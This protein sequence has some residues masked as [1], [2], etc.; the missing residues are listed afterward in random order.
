LALRDC[1]RL[2]VPAFRASERCDWQ[3]SILGRLEARPETRLRFPRRPVLSLQSSVGIIRHPAGLHLRVT[4]NALDRLTHAHLSVSNRC[5]GSVQRRQKCYAVLIGNSWKRS[6]KGAGVNECKKPDFNSRLPYSPSS[7][8]SQEG[9]GDW[10]ELFSGQELFET[11]LAPDSE[12]YCATA[13]A[14]AM[15]AA[16]ASL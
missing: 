16:I 3:D 14:V 7:G 15:A 6:G 12:V 10:S 1:V 13:L 2:Q 11:A 9:H 5:G 8:H 4:P